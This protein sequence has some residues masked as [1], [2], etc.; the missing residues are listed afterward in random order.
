M[1]IFHFLKNK[2]RGGNSLPERT[3]EPAPCFPFAHDY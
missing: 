2:I 3:G 1:L